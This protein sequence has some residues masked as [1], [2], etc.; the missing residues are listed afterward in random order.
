MKDR[1]MSRVRQ[2]AKTQD[3][4]TVEIESGESLVLTIV[5]ESSGVYAVNYTEDGQDKAGQ[6]VDAEDAQELYEASE[7][8][9]FAG[10]DAEFEAQATGNDG[11]LR[12][13]NISE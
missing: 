4:I 12:W 1:T 5:A 13:V 10:D 7:D 8:D 9:S 6:F 3:T 11:S 2:I